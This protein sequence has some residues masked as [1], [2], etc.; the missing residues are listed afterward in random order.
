[1]RSIPPL[2]ALPAFEAAMRHGSFTLASRELNVTPGAIGQ[3][4]QKLEEW[5]GVATVRAPDTAGN[6][7]RGWS[8]LLRADSTRPGRA[9]S[10]EPSHS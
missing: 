9:Y 4:I 7:D 8:R 10:C 6:A 3:Q 2:K 5:L 1:M